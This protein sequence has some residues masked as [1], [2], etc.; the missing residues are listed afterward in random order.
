MSGDPSARGSSS[1]PPPEVP[2]DAYDEGY[3][4]DECWGASAWNAS[5]GAEVAGIYPGFLARFGVGKVATLIDIGTGRGEMLVVAVE[6]GASRAI[7]FEYSIAALKLARQTLRLR[8]VGPRATVVGADARALPVRE[9]SADVVTM[10]EVV[11]HLTP[12]EFSATLREAHRVL[13]PGGRLLIHTAPT[14]TIYN[15]TY[16]LQRW[17]RPSR[18]RSWPEEPRTESERVVHV[19]EQTVR[20]LRRSLV[21]AGFRPTVGLGAWVHTEHIPDPGAKRIYHLL[22]RLPILKRFAIADVWAEGIR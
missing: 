3:Y 6:N 2:S 22:G 12:A 15:V 17:L 5:G 18:R 21:S 4:R 7:G 13:R 14:S 19:N 11:E 20:R 16:R 10:L 8:N 1:L 9:A